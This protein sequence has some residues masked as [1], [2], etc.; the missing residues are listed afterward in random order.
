MPCFTEELTDSSRFGERERDREEGLAG[1]APDVDRFRL[2]HRH[3]LVLGS[4]EHGENRLVE[5]R[6][7]TRAN[8]L[9]LDRKDLS[10]GRRHDAKD[11]A[12]LLPLGFVVCFGGCHRFRIHTRSVS[13]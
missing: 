11:D 9:R 5:A 6:I 3:V 12:M 7:A 2:G 13:P 1:V 8:G 4:L 10:L